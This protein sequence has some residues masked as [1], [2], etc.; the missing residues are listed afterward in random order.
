MGKYHVR[1]FLKSKDF[2]ASNVSLLY[3]RSGVFGTSIGGICSIISFVL[4]AYWLAVNIWSTLAPPGQFTDLVSMMVVETTPDGI[5]DPIDVPIAKL[6]TAYYINQTSLEIDNI[7]DYVV[8]L[9][10]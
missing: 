3:K 9:W 5:Y 2:Y 10:F 8:G 4:L 6:L 1:Q 7:E